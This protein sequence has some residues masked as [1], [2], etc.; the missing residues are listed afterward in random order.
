MQTAASGPLT[1]AN[2]RPVMVLVAAM[3]GI[4]LVS[5]DVSVVNV[6]LETLR[7]SFHVR[8]NDLQWV[9]NVYTLGYA[10]FLL[11]AGALSDRLGS[12]MTFVLGSAVFTLSSL[13]CGLAPSFDLLLVARTIQGLGA[14]LLVPSSMAMLQQSIPDAKARARAVGLWAGA[15]SLAIVAGPVL[16]GALIASVGWR[17]IFLINLPIGLLGI[18]LT[19]RHAPRSGRGAK[20]GL[21]LAGQSAAAV[22]LACFVGAVTQASAFGWINPWILGG[23]T[24][25]TALFAGFLVIEARSA[26]PMMPLDLFRDRTFAL[27]TFVGV[28]V[29]L[30]F[31][32][33]LFMFSLFF[34]IVQGKSPFATGM[35][36]VPM[37]VVIMFANVA[38]GRL[39]GRF[40]V[41]PIML[42]GLGIASIGYPAMLLIGADSTYLLVTPIFAT[43]GI[44]VALT[45][46]SVMTA[47]L[48]GTHASRTGIA[49]GVLNSAR[50][51]GGAVG[52][53]IFGSTIY[54]AAPSTF[55]H[56][57]HISIVLAGIAIISTFLLAVLLLPAQGHTDE[58]HS[59]CKIS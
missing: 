16:G 41:R 34:Q 58:Y 14:A 8:V 6:A 18:W 21:D 29:N 2:T 25:G 24:C 50:Q 45:V 7:R 48:T 43:A 17:G 23:L 53:A 22:A 51:V 49:T 55:V 35:A 40:G 26:H 11:S 52:V 19:L 38:A 32:G 44:G 12:R 30:V 37:T 36:F 39:I 57:M 28:V 1:G 9:L 3:M 10:V 31:Y 4:V 13:A 5:L 15:G 27:A 46:P 56:G 54:A 59:P 42:T 33:L 47:A 20:R